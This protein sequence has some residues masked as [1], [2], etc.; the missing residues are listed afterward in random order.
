MNPDWSQDPDVIRTIVAL[1][2]ATAVHK[3][4]KTWR[5]LLTKQTANLAYSQAISKYF[6]N[7][8]K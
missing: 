1:D 6:A 2:Q 3:K 5:S 4:Q 7:K 8:A